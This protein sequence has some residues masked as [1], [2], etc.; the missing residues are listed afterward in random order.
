VVLLAAYLCLQWRDRAGSSPDF[1]F[2]PPVGT[3]GQYQ[4]YHAALPE[5]LGIPHPFCGVRGLMLRFTYAFASFGEPA[6]EEPQQNPQYSL[7]FP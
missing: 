5:A 3:L 6:K 4:R 1:P 7:R 2:K